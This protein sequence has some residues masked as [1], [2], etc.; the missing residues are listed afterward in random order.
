MICHS[1]VVKA[2]MLVAIYITY[3]ALAYGVLEMV[4]AQVGNPLEEVSYGVYDARP[5]DERM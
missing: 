4:D 3:C 1:K 5:K 2:V